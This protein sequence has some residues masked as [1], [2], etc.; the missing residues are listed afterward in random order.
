LR[1]ARADSDAA[2]KFR[3]AERSAMADASRHFEGAPEEVSEARAILLQEKVTIQTEKGK[4][5]PKMPSFW[6]PS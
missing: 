4:I 2:D 5:V 3:K 6:I 1:Q